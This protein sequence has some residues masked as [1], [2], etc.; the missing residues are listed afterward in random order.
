ML[1]ICK[2]FSSGK[3]VRTNKVTSK[4]LKNEVPTRKQ[5][6]VNGVLVGG[7]VAPGYELLKEEF[8]NQFKRDID[9]DIQGA[10]VTAYGTNL[11][12]YIDVHYVAYI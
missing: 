11:T 5:S 1:S 10:A 6:M 8:M 7:T 4:V 9:H 2:G 3:V 12:I